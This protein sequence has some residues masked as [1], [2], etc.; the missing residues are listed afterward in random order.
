M[1]LLMDKKKRKRPALV[2]QAL[3][4]DVYLGTIN[5]IKLKREDDRTFFLF[6]DSRASS[7]DGWMERK[8]R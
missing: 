1:R 4:A 7:V 5:D 3:L 6:Q 2:L 8:R